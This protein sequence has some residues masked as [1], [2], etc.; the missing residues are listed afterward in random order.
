MSFVYQITILKQPVE[1]HTII[2]A[3]LICAGVIIT[4][5]GLPIFYKIK[6]LFT[7]KDEND[8]QKSNI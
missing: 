7:K 1:V 2:G 3:V 8:E 4:S 5:V 6:S